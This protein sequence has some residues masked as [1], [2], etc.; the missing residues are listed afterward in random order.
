MKLSSNGTSE[1]STVIGSLITKTMLLIVALVRN[2]SNAENRLSFMKLGK[3]NFVHG[4]PSA[5]WAS[6]LVV[7]F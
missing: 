2:G 6:H 5:L 1:Q 4:L 7:V 3:V